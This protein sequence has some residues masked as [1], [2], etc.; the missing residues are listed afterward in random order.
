[1]PVVDVDLDKLD[2]PESRPVAD[3]AKLARMGPFDAAKYTPIIVEKSSGG[4]FIIQKG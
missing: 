4:R 1:M 2:P 3:P